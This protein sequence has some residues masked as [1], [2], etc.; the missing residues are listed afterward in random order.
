[1]KVKRIFLSR[2]FHELFWSI[3]LSVGIGAIIVFPSL[4]QKTAKLFKQEHIQ[5]RA[6]LADTQKP[7]AWWDN[8]GGCGVGGGGGGGAAGPKWLGRSVTGGLVNIESRLS[9]GSAGKT[10]TF[11][12]SN[13]FSYDFLYRNTIGLTMPFSYKEGKYQF[14]ND[15]SAK[16]ISGHTGG[17][18][19]IGIDYSRKFGE[20]EALSLT[21]SSSIPTGKHNIRKNY[22]DPIIQG[23]T[24]DGKFYLPPELQLGTGVFSLSLSADYTLDKDWGPVLFGLTYTSMLRSFSDIIKTGAQNRLFKK[25][26]AGKYE[27]FSGQKGIPVGALYASDK[28]EDSLGKLR[29][30]YF[31]NSIGASIAAGYR[32]ERFVHSLQA[33]Y[34]FK[35]SPDWYVRAEEPY[36]NIENPGT[37][38]GW[39]YY[40]PAAVSEGRNSFSVSYGIEKSSFY[41][42]V[43]FGLSASFTPSSF[44]GISG[45]LGVKASVL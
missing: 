13:R 35:L 8:I 6:K 40:L 26:A 17:I 38:E 18:G 20:I 1:M 25:D 45:I 21:L 41:C 4:W 14:R 22:P 16:E 32:T 31:G 9:G 37:G 27:D 43:F 2:G 15:A 42:P 11:T 19:D 44:N 10:Q 36:V 34:T 5:G 29:G 23:Q 33:V 7:L 28:N 3:S 24:V 30:D 39:N 12:L